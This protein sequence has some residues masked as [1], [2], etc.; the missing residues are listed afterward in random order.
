MNPTSVYCIWPS[1]DGATL[2]KRGTFDSC[3]QYVN[4]IEDDVCYFNAYNK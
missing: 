2:H 4:C 1:V 3:N